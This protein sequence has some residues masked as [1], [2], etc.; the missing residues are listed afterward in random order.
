[1]P[2][3]THARSLSVIFGAVMREVPQQ[4]EGGER[5]CQAVLEKA[6]ID[7]V[8]MDVTALV[9]KELQACLPLLSSS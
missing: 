5:W 8:Y 1:M 4:A 2:R 6:S 7:E 3:V 9:D